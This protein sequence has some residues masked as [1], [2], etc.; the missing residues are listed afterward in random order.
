[1][2][3]E[4]EGAKRRLLEEHERDLALAW[5]IEAFAR[6]KR[7][8]KLDTLLNQGKPRKQ[9]PEEMRSAIRGMI[10]EYRGTKKAGHARRSGGTATDD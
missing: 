8:P 7:L 4:L 3:R 2:Q 6:T 9:T 10:G 5:Y 1:V